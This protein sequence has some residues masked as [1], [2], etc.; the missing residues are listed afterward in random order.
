VRPRVFW[1]S[2]NGRTFFATTG[3]TYE[4]R[5]GGTPDGELLAATGQPYV[6]ALETQRFDAGALGQFL[7]KGLY[8][9]TARAAVVRQSHDHQFGEVIERDRHDTIFGEVAVRGTAG[10]QTWVGGLAIERD[11]YTAVYGS[12]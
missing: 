3:F 10:R 11:A 5:D 1:D 8:V 7:F 2:G 12:P 9:V 6:E 4:D